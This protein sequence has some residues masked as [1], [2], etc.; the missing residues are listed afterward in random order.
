MLRYFFK[1]EFYGHP[2]SK[3]D[4]AYS[5]LLII[6]PLALLFTMA[7]WTKKITQEQVLVNDQNLIT[8]EEKQ[9]EN[10]KQINPNISA[11]AAFVKRLN[12]GEIV[13]T[14]NEDVA[15]PLASITKIM[16]ALVAIKEAGDLNKKIVIN[17]QD[18]E[19]E[20]EYNMFAGELF[21]T[22]DL[23]DFSLVISANDASSALA[24]AFN[25][26]K[27]PQG[28][29]EFLNK[30]NQMAKSIGLEKTL[31][32]NETG[33][34]V[35]TLEAGAYGSAKDVSTLMEYVYKNYPD[36][37][38]STTK[39]K[40]III[41]EQGL[42]HTVNNTNEIINQIPGILGSKTGYTDIAGGNLAIIADLGLNDPYIIVVLGSTQKGR[43]DD[44]LEIINQIKT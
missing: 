19:A 6:I 40:I 42:V 32:K 33:L 17:Y 25:S 3:K 20:G 38:Y 10:T 9:I 41:S 39:D 35:N 31:F 8:I 12:T 22:R 11:R 18:L 14:K 1:K 30:M 36:L 29:Q 5:F 4:I 23:L 24:S 43:F 21:T 13:Y 16:T 28:K 27:N 34:D 37:L 2:R 15:L 7:I 26:F 44:I